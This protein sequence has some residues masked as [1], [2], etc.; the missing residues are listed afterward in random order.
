M[1]DPARLVF[2]DE[3]CTTT[4]MVRLRGRCPHGVRLIGRT[5]HGHWKTITFVAGLRYRAI[6][7]PLVIDGAM[8]APMFLVYLKQCLVPTLKRGDVVIMDSRP[9]HKAPGVREMIEAAG[10]TL[11]YLPP[12]SPDLNPIEQALQQI[13]GAPTKGGRDDCSR[14]LAQDRSASGHLQPTRMQKLLAPCGLCSNVIGIRSLE[15]FSATGHRHHEPTF[16][17]ALG[18]GV[19]NKDPLSLS[20]PKIDNPFSVRRNNIDDARIG[21]SILSHVERVI[22]SDV[23]YPQFVSLV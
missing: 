6:V 16:H 14:P 7:A 19:T 3:T 22:C 5:P 11:L 18:A 15:A 20:F 8:N 2:I 21:S 12:N 23:Y 17:P 10:A 9:L 4:N 1:F 13:D